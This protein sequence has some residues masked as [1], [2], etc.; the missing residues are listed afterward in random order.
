MLASGPVGMDAVT[1]LHSVGVP[2]SVDWDAS[3]TGDGYRY[4]AS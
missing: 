2:V 4:R 3:V 1:L